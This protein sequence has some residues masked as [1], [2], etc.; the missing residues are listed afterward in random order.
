M[1]Q[2]Y[3]VEIAQLFRSGFPSHIANPRFGRL[4]NRKAFGDRLDNPATA[5]IVAQAGGFLL[6]LYQTHQRPEVRSGDVMSGTPQPNSHQRATNSAGMCA[7]SSPYRLSSTPITGDVAIKFVDRWLFGVENRHETPRGV[8]TPEWK[9]RG[10]ILRTSV[11]ISRSSVTCGMS[12]PVFMVSGRFQSGLPLRNPGDGSAIQGR[13]DTSGSFVA[14]G[15]FRLRVERI[16]PS[17]TVMPTP[18]RLPSR[19]ESRMSLPGAC[20]A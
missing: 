19:T 17:I 5:R 3:P 16:S 18:G 12:Y 11:P 10:H 4:L 9:W 13:R 2:K 8:E 15:V 20:C 1:S 7:R 14:G 6:A